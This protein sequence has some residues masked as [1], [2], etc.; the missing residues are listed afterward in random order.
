MVKILQRSHQFLISPAPGWRNITLLEISQILATPWTHTPPSAPSCTRPSLHIH[1]QTGNSSLSHPIFPSTTCSVIQTPASSM[2]RQ[3]SSFPSLPHLSASSRALLSSSPSSILIKNCSYRLAME[4]SSR[5][6]T[7]HDIEWVLLSQKCPNRASLAYQLKQ[8]SLNDILTSEAMQSIK[9]VCYA[10]KSFVNSSSLLKELYHLSHPVSSTQQGLINRL[11]IS[12]IENHL[13]ISLS[14]GGNDLPLFKR[15]YKFESIE[16]K[17]EVNAPSLDVPSS[18]R[19]AVA[20]LAE[21]HAAACFLFMLYSNCVSE[22]NTCELSIEGCVDSKRFNHLIKNIDRIV[23][24]FAG[25]GG[26]NCL[27]SSPSN[28]QYRNFGI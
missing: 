24:P 3:S 4:I 13:T 15:G 5:L 21:H 7:G 26:S 28:L 20:P 16:M 19:L 14:F 27:L 12:L 25:S 6:L 8:F 10:N 11:K 17:D 9:V 18:S 2:N 1:N 22:Q 23:I